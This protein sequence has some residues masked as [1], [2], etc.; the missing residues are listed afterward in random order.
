MY[1]LKQTCPK[2]IGS[3]AFES[4]AKTRKGRRDSTVKRRPCLLVFGLQG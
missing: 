1:K 3:R 2:Q 4:T